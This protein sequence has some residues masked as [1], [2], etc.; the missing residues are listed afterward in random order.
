MK[1]HWKFMFFFQRETKSNVSRVRE[2][3]LERKRELSTENQRL[4]V[5]PI[6][7]WAPNWSSIKAVAKTNNSNTF[8][9]KVNLQRQQSLEWKL[10]HFLFSSLTLLK[11]LEMINFLA[12][13]ECFHIWT[14]VSCH[15]FLVSSKYHPAT[16]KFS[17]NFSTLLKM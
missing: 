11:F 10:K 9:A 7:E 6:R 12:K 3:V 15:S 1:R 4:F 5:D 16:K 2:W 13:A 8:L 14:S 17:Y